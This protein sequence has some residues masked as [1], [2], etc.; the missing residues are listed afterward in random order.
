LEKITKPNDSFKGERI[1][2]ILRGIG[3]DSTFYHEGE[4]SLIL[5]HESTSLTEIGI[6]EA[7]TSSGEFRDDILY[8]DM[9]RAHGRFL[10][11]DSQELLLSSVAISCKAIN[12][13]DRGKFLSDL[14]SKYAAKVSRSSVKQLAKIESVNV[15]HGQ[16]A[17]QYEYYSKLTAKEFLKSTNDFSNYTDEWLEKVLVKASRGWKTPLWNPGKK[18]LGKNRG[19]VIPLLRLTAGLIENPGMMDRVRFY[20]QWAL[21]GLTIFGIAAITNDIFTLGYTWTSI[22]ERFLNNP[23]SNIYKRYADSVAG[24]IVAVGAGFFGLRLRN[25]RTGFKNEFNRLR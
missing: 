2:N 18:A 14:H 15:G 22:C 24:V 21:L 20:L 4:L 23:E 16:H 9:L 19:S 11:S 17:W 3:D 6:T 10:G 13:Y 7:L 8:S 5:E 1:A 12:L 25:T